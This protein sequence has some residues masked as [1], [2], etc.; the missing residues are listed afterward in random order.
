MKTFKVEMKQRYKIPPMLMEKYKDEICFMVE[1]NFTCMEAIIP[2]VMFIEPIG[3]EMSTE[4]TE[5]YA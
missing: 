2:R 5:G 1:T 4:L 3:Y